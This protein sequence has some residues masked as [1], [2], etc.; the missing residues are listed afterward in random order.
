MTQHAFSGEMKDV[1]TVLEGELEFAKLHHPNRV[2]TLVKNKCFTLARKTKSPHV[3]RVLQ[4]ISSVPL[5]T[6]K[7]EE[8]LKLY[9]EV[10]RGE[11]ELSVVAI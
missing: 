4:S 6:A 7:L 5:S 10:E 2:N 8:V 1:L 9:H 11:V 3:K